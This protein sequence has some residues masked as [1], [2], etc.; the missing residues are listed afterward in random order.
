MGGKKKDRVAQEKLKLAAR[1]RGRDSEDAE[2][3]TSVKSGTSSEKRRLAQTRAELREA[4]EDALRMAAAHETPTEPPIYGPG[5]IFD[6]DDDDD[7][8]D[9]DDEIET[10]REANAALKRRLHKYRSTVGA[11]T[12]LLA[13]KPN[14]LAPMPAHP[15][16]VTKASDILALRKFLFDWLGYYSFGLRLGPQERKM[17]TP[18]MLATLEANEEEFRTAYTTSSFH[19]LQQD[20]YLALKKLLGQCIML[21]NLFNQVTTETSTCAS[22]LWDL[23]LQGFPLRSPQVVA[24][25]IAEAAVKIM[26]GPDHG[27][28]DPAKAFAAWDEAVSHLLYLGEVTLTSEQLSAILMFASL[29]GSPNDLYYTAY[30]RLNDSLANN[31][32]KFDATTVRAAALIAF[33]AEQRRLKK[34]PTQPASVPASVLGFAA[35]VVGPRRSAPTTGTHSAGSGCCKCPHHCRFADGTFRVV[36][37]ADT[38]VVAHVGTVAV[39]PTSAA[40][41]QALLIYHAA[42]DDLDTP[43]VDIAFLRGVFEAERQADVDRADPVAY[44]AATGTPYHDFSDED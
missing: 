41:R 24:G 30:V 23:I 33:N 14:S 42:L 3:E 15:P 36:R 19:H 7:D 10:L 22:S 21:S 1:G 4:G 2:S 44:A 25:L 18:A 16:T 28:T 6:A 20:I 26:R 37:A 31:S 27:A 17:L 11:A 8:D 32:S 29:H 35:N 40:S 43:A 13:W 12:R 5:N 9:D 39:A 34:H 38:A